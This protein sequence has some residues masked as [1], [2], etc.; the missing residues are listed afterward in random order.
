MFCLCESF[1]KVK[2]ISSVFSV[3]FVYCRNMCEMSLELREKLDN[4]VCEILDVV[5]MVVVDFVFMFVKGNYYLR[6]V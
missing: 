4:E 3:F 1:I 6:S 2:M 5:M